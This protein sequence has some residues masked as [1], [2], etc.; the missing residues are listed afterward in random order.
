MIVRRWRELLGYSLLFRIAESLLFAPIA[1]LAG[2]WLLGRTVLDSTALVSFVL[3]PCGFTALA[4]AAIAA[5][6]LRLG[7]HAG[8]SVIFFGALNDRKVSAREAL[9]LVWRNALDLVRVSARLVGAGL[10]TLLP[11]AAVSGWFAIRLLRQHDVNYYLKF[12]PTEFI[13]AIISIGVVACA[14]GAV[15]LWLV[16]RWRWVVQVVLFEQK[17]P[18]EAFAESRTLTS[19]LRWK[20]L[21]TFLGVIAVMAGLG[22]IASLLGSLCASVVLS[23]M[24][25][26]V[27]SL[28][29][30]FGVL[31]LLRVVVGAIC[32]FLGSCVDAGV[33]TSLYHRRAL[34]LGRKA[35]I[36]GEE[37]GGHVPPP[38]WLPWGLALGSLGF[39][40]C[41][42]WLATDAIPEE[43]PV[44]IHAHR[45][46]ATRA[47]EN[48]LPAVRDAIASGADYLETDVQLTKDDVLVVTHD[49]DFSRLGGVAK[50][51]W[52]LTYDEIRAIPLGAGSVPEFRNECAPSFDSLLAE[53]KGRIKVNI[54]MK[55]YGDH[56]P[57]L[58]QKIVNAVSARGMLDQVIIQCLEYEP[59]LEVRR[60]A[61]QVPIGYLLAFN[62]RK[63]KRLE[64][65]FLSVEEKRVDR[66]FVQD[67]HRRGQLVYVWTVDKAD[68]FEHL[69]DLGIDGVITNQSELMR[70]TLSKYLSRPKPERA[71]RRVRSW[72]AD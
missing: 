42:A 14:V 23:L 40:V 33:F 37:V 67:A 52:D 19:G 34:E 12:R 24:D 46:V 66:A 51:V 63:P 9:R 50:K 72:L 57:G 44:T 45:G 30:S 58:A 39:V 41:A 11:L 55:Y 60:L 17:E 61:P 10:L 15:L 22:L 28:A 43:R 2:K 54:E 53:T 38:R 48:S 36:T 16:L 20:L 18:R 13:A 31:L 3:S 8:L 59:L 69:L 29:I 26:S 65:N 5:M 32:T 4:L 64:V 47:P 21:L 25:S 56:Q 35:S 62:A 68:D 27:T 71:V 1:G 70:K 49:S 6:S 7:E